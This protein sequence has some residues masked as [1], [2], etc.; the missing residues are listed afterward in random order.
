M[1]SRLAGCDAAPQHP[2]LGRLMAVR[3]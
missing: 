1:S 2:R 3:A